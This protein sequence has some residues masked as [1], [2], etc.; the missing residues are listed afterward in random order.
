MAVRRVAAHVATPISERTD[1]ALR[2][3]KPGTVFTIS[4]AFPKGIEIGLHLLVD[5]RDRPIEGVDL[6]QME[7]EQEAVASRQAASQR[8]AKLLSGRLD[9][10]VGQAS[11]DGRIGL[12]SDHRLDHRPAADAQAARGRWRQ[13]EVLRSPRSN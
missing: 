4:T 6:L 7:L 9:P 8:L 2:S 11:Q 10:P 5:P 12:S 1:W 3:S 13:S